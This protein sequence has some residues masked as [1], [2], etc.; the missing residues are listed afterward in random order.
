GNLTR[1]ERQIAPDRS[2]FRKVPS[3]NSS[4]AARSCSCVFITIGPYQATGSSSGF[5][6]T[7]R[8]RIPSSPACTVTSSPRANSTSERLSAS[9]GG[10]VSDQPTPSVGT[11]SGPDELQYFPPPAKT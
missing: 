6:D 8:N 4:N 10:A 3:C 9:L 11:A 7:R 1:P 2:Y 5:P